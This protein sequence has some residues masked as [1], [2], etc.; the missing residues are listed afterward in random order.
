MR[1]IYNSKGG[2]DMVIY[3]PT[4]GKNA[5]KKNFQDIKNCL[6]EKPNITGI[7]IAKILRISKVTVY[8]HLK[9]LQK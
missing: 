3:E 9:K 1:N 5:G 6:I 4:T 8:S 2:D 7:E